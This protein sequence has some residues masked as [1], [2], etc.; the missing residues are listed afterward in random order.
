[1]LTVTNDIK[2]HM[3]ISKTDKIVFIQTYLLYTEEWDKNYRI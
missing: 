3:D 1:M 2:I